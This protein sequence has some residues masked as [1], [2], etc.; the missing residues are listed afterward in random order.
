MK[1]FRQTGTLQ[2][3]VLAAGTLLFATWLIMNFHV[4]TGEQSGLI[5]FFLTLAFSIAILL[6]PK[7]ETPGQSAHEKFS[8][9]FYIIPAIAG[10]LGVLAGII[11]D[12][13]QFEWLGLLVII[14]ACLRWTLHPSFRKDI[15]Y[16]LFLLYWAHPLPGFI[17]G[18]MQM[19]AQKISVFGSEWLLQV[20]NVRVWADGLVLYTGLN[21]FEIPE[22][23]S[24][25]RTSV[26]VLLLTLGLGILKRFKWQECAILAVI[27]VVQAAILNILRIT[28]MVALA[29]STGNWAGIDFLHNTAGIIVIAAVFLTYIEISFWRKKKEGRLPAA[30][31]RDLHGAQF[32]VGYPPFWSW[33]YAN[34]KSILITATLVVLGC[35]AAFKSRPRHR[36][37]MIKDVATA[38]RDSGSIQAAQKAAEEVQK[39]VPYD[40]EWNMTVIRI[41]IIRQK[42]TEALVSLMNITATD[43]S[44]AAEKD[45]LKAYCLMGLQKMPEAAAIVS[46]MPPDLREKDPRVA[47][48]LA[49]IAFHGRKP[50]EVARRVVI[51]SRWFPNIPRIRALY[52]FLRVYR[53][54]KAIADSDLKVPYTDPAQALSAMEAYMNINNIPVLASML[55]TAIISWPDDPR[56][57][58]PLFFMAMKHGEGDWEKKFSAHFAK[59][60]PAIKEPDI[61][62]PLFAKCFQL[63]RPDLA[64]L[65]YRRIESIDASH[66]SLYMCA[67]TYGDAWFVFR[68]RFLAMNS[69]LEE[70]K[71]DIKHIFLLTSSFNPWKE[72]FKQV[73]LAE[74]LAVANTVKTRRIFLEKALKE[75]EIRSTGGRLT[76]AMQYE[77]ARALEMKGLPEQAVAALNRI[78]A[79]HPD[80][81]ERDSAIISEIYERTGNWQNVYEILRGY[82]SNENP[83]LSPLLRLCQAQMELKLNLAALNTAREAVRMFPD[84]ILAAGSLA[85]VLM[86]LDAT[87]EALFVLGQ[88][89]TRGD[90]QMDLAEAEALFSTQR[91]SEFTAFSRSIFLPGMSIPP[92]ARQDD[93]LRSA[94]LSLFWHL[95]STPPEASFAQNAAML[96][97]N[98]SSATSPFMR[99]M[100]NLW[101]ECYGAR[102]G[103]MTADPDKWLACGRDNTE[104]AVALNQLT[105]L[106]CR[107]G[108]FTEARN[109]AGIAVKYMP[110]SPVLWQVLISLSNA[111]IDV[112][113]AARRSCPD[114]PEIWL[115]E[116][117]VRT[118]ETR[119]LKS[120]ALNT[121]ASAVREPIVPW[122]EDTV[123]NKLLLAG[124][125]KTVKN[126]YETT[127]SGYP[128]AAVARAGEYLLRRGYK[129]AAAIAAYDAARRARGLLPA[130]L[131]ALKCAIAENDKA[132]I[133]EYTTLAL[134]SSLHPSAVLYK[135]MIN[136]K[137]AGQRIDAD[138]DMI[139]ALK[140]LRQNEPGNLVWAQILGYVRFMRGGLD[141]VD[142]LSQMT[143]VIDAGATNKIPYI[144]A[145][146]A[147]RQLG[148]HERA[149]EFLRAGL[150]LHPGN[151]E[152]F[153]NL[154]YTL[155]LSPR[156]G[157]NSLPNTLSPQQAAVEMIPELTRIGG[158]DPRVMDTVATAYIQAGLPDKAERAIAHILAK[159]KEGS[160]LW[161]RARLHTACIAAKKGKLAEAETILREILRSSR[162][163]PDEDIINANKLLMEVSSAN[164]KYNPPAPPSRK[165]R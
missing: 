89:R 12:V 46:K 87:E 147:A 74:D 156:T 67:A 159:S 91:Y 148:N 58:E 145:A 52:P 115:A 22:W 38:L 149:G 3:V 164:Q 96:R 8:P 112:I 131:L 28:A 73:P 150:K 152:M 70:E 163:V 45:I 53:K 118:R 62:C 105:L 124:M 98:V 43:P 144:I 136:V 61:L 64:W 133:S 27:A 47:M 83:A 31:E 135:Q 165:I 37:E 107:G 146:E 66:P 65:L 134:K 20:L 30:P 157:I 15:F 16:S 18:P 40:E 81:E 162:E 44:Y 56:I 24:G 138:E 49:E 60:V 153:N 129:K 32:L 55:R 57:L 93:F 69:P 35:G 141:T 82:L 122:P 119:S 154:V 50:D 103:G 140:K 110:K 1:L 101:L 88:S 80:L 34:R 109:V 100:M 71:T 39:L 155:A 113:D 79:S 23:C 143:S 111:D 25:M 151:L 132:K 114:D 5:R 84:S 63:S 78:T 14:L 158:D 123:I 106:L 102:C 116:L 33:A 128:P 108:K 137:Y 160:H 121:G 92:D 54:W 125:M 48:I 41:L 9:G 42:Y 117:V 161:F 95:T 104:K 90:S 68:K 126:S 26:T 6:R 120:Q 29:P 97:R 13:R 77:Y 130:Y 94:E 85:I 4:L 17:F 10:T 36:A 59:C 11:F 127:L 99:N 139:E 76:I 142:S 86:N 21:T 51:A 72:M 7:P 2:P 19:A 75:F